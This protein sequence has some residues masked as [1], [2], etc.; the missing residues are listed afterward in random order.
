MKSPNAN[1]EAGVC[2]PG[3]QSWELWKHG[4]GGW[5]PAQSGA[6]PSEFK[7]ASVF[8]YAVSAAFALPVRA[9]T[10]DEDLLPDIV[11]FQLEKANLRPE[12]PVGRIMDW[13]LVER[14][15]NR[16][17]L[18]ASV[19]NAEMADDLPK[20]APGRF[21]VS[22]YLYYLPDDSLV[23]WKELG[24]L[25]FAV[26]RGD[27]P[28]YYHA[29]NAQ[30][31]TAAAV[32]EIEQLLM[33]LYTQEIIARLEAVV[34]WTEAVEP[35]AAEA[36]GQVLGVRVKSER[37]PAPA[38][39]QAQSSF[40]PVSVAMSKIRAARLRKVRNIVM[41]CLVGYLAVPGFF[42]A[43]WYLAGQ[44]LDKLR[45]EVSV[46]Q[47]NFGGV[48]PAIARLKA[49]DPILNP[50]KYPIEL[51]NQVI[52]PLYRPGNQVRL[53]SVE[54]TRKAADGGPERGEITA[55]LEAN[56]QTTSAATLYVTSVRNNTALKD[57]DWSRSKAEEVKN[58]KVPIS[59]NGDIKSTEEENAE[60][61]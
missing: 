41:A 58:Q 3:E 32:A 56:S 16:T 37:K 40:E 12:T 11:E 26:T 38:V 55:K 5:Q 60:T 57:F 20:D 2:L 14:E 31:L 48:E 13:R 29:L 1:L 25:V 30:V 49:L 54:I 18:L 46:M 53:L 4:S 7:T 28:I 52:S 23:I 34:L 24:R 47:V 19:L 10:G 27:Q 61:E 17:L 59:L 8:G 9:A 35:G 15:E 44:E 6:E 21:E 39:P 51:L 22:P 45:R 50:N 43:R 42:A 33:P 36:L